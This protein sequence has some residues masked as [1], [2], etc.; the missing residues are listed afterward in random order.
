MGHVAVELFLDAYLNSQHPGKLERFYQ[1]V[2][3][4]DGG[5]VQRTIN[6]FASRPTDKLAMAIERFIRIRFLFDYVTDEGMVFWINKVL[7]RVKLEPLGEQILDWM[8]GARRRVY[9]NVAGLL[10]QY[11]L[12]V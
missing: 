8:P 4:V 7:K 2:A 12:E 3:S 9:D 11:A 1:Q 10:P 5:Q 6:L